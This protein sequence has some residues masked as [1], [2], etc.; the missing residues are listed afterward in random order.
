M[1]PFNAIDNRLNSLLIDAMSKKGG[2]LAFTGLLWGSLSS[3]TG[4]QGISKELIRC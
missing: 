2:I 4:H 3:G 1:N